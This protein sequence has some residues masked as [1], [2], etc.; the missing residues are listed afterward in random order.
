MHGG[1]GLCGRSARLPEPVIT[2]DS[3]RMAVLKALFLDLDE[4]LSDTL[5]AN[6]QARE[7]MGR[8]RKR[9]HIGLDPAPAAAGRRTGTSHIASPW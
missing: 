8:T 6:E 2:V 7:L 4:T 5:G 3:S 1:S 9:N